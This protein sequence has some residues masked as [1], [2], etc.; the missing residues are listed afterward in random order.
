MSTSVLSRRGREAP[1]SPIRKLEPL[2]RKAT[3]RGT[4]IYHLNIGQPDIATPTAFVSRAQLRPGEVLSY[5]PSAGLYPYRQAL[6]AYYTATISDLAV[7]ITEAD[8]L[9]TTGGSEALLF[10]M[11]ALCDPGDEIITPEPYYPN[12]GMFALMAGA[13]L[14]PLP[15]RIEDGFRLPPPAAFAAA[16]TPRTRAILLCNPSNPTGA[17]YSRAALTEVVELCRSRGLIL[18]CDEVYRDFIYADGE[19][20]RPQSVLQI[21][22]AAEVSVVIDSLSK[23]FSACGARIGCLLSKN[24]EIIDAATRFAMSRLS[25]PTLGQLGGLGALEEPG[26]FVAGMIE[27]FRRRRDVLMQELGRLPG[28]VAPQAQGAFYLMTRL[29]VQSSERFC[30]WLLTDFSDRGETVMLAPGPGFYRTSG[31]GQDEVRIAYVLGE[32]PLRRAVEL[33]GLALQKYPGTKQA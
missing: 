20:G 6:A 28:V 33:L 18:I 7:P 27:K 4:K 29:P 3:E 19:A 2:A 21:P 1:A 10:T 24:A 8:V 30:E 12:Y 16:V 17:V 14:R 9:V 31:S 11:F 25:P 22:G 13:V 15:T 23:R 5:S 26:P 32:E